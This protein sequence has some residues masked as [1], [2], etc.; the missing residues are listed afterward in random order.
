LFGR[1]RAVPITFII[2][3]FLN[4]V[5][6]LTEKN[7]FLLRFSNEERLHKLPENGM[8]NQSQSAAASGAEEWRVKK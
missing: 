2:A 3:V 7:C 4:E 1:P 8:M 6:L 5:Y